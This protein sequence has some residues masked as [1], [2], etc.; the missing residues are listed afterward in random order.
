MRSANPGKAAPAS[1]ERAD[2]RPASSAPALSISHADLEQQISCTDLALGNGFGLFLDN[3]MLY[4][5]INQPKI[6]TNQTKWLWQR[7]QTMF[8]ILEAGLWV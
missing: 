8:L 1:T 6:S 3:N 4:K 5:K 2:A 7:S